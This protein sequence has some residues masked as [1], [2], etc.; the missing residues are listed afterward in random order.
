MSLALIAALP[1]LGALLPGLMIRA[2]RDACAAV[3]AAVTLVALILLALEA[4]AVL[5]GGVV[6]TRIDWL[7]ALGL[8]VT[9]FLDSLG[10]MFAGL[11]L[12]IG[13]LVTLYAR[14][15]LAASDPMGRFFVPFTQARLKS[16]YSPRWKVDGELVLI[17]RG[18]ISYSHLLPTL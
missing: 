16:Q 2:G 6:Q 8:N 3:T 10:L 11:I 7:P 1:F 15:Y 13:L 5:Q 14:F 17:N 12:G 4:P 18:A 9:F